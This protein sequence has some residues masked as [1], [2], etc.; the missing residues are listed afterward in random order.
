MDVSNNKENISEKEPILIPPEQTKKPEIPAGFS[1]SVLFEKEKNSNEKIT[2]YPK[3]I[4][5][6]KAVIFIVVAILVLIFGIFSIVQISLETKYPTIILEENGNQLSENTNDS[7]SQDIENEEDHTIIENVNQCG[8]VPFV[9]ILT[10]EINQVFKIGDI[11]DFRFELCGISPRLFTKVV[12]D[13]FDTDTM[14]YVNSF[15]LHCIESLGSFEN[16]I[17]TIS[18]KVPPFLEVKTN[19]PNCLLPVVNLLNSYTYKIKVEYANGLYKDESDIF[20]I[21]GKEYTY[22][23]PQFSEY[24][25]SPDSSFSRSPYIDSAAP[26][27]LKEV[28]FPAYFQAPPL[29]ANYYRWYIIPRGPAYLIDL[30]DGKVYPSPQT[31]GQ[32]IT[33]PLSYLYISEDILADKDKPLTSQTHKVSWFVFHEETKTFENLTQRFCNVETGVLESLYTNCI[34]LN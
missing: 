30:R 28:I 21:D 11:I 16:D 27:F 33:K 24:L 29:F 17:Q 32:V 18:W 10:P 12:I 7:I 13:Y 15:S 14:N 22:T 1:S 4:N 26:D 25:I 6:T 8:D 34:P 20:F 2:E 3:K 19:K 23:P 5:H 31:T 9:K